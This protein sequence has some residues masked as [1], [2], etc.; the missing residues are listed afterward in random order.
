MRGIILLKALLLAGCAENFDT[1][2]AEADQAPAVSVAAAASPPPEM[3]ATAAA[4]KTGPEAPPASPP[5]EAEIGLFGDPLPAPGGKVPD[6]T[7][8]VAS[9]RDATRSLGIQIVLSTE[10]VD[11][12]RDPPEGQA[13]A[14]PYPRASIAE[15]CAAGRL[16]CYY[17]RDFNTLAVYETP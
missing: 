14:A 13:A 10:L 2:I 4:G 12:L 9:L 17:V 16:Y 7:A 3:A 15:L 5:P 1:L 6:L 8:I 11:Q